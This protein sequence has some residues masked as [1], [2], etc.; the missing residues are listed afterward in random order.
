[1]AVD[2]TIQIADDRRADLSMVSDCEASEK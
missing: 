1:M 2:A